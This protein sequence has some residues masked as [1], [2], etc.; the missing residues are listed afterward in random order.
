M[1]IQLA[2]LVLW[3]AINII[4]VCK[5]TAKKLYNDL[6]V[7]QNWF[8]RIAGNLFYLPAWLIIGLYS[9]IIV[10]VFLA[11]AA[12]AWVAEKMQPLVGRVLRGE[13]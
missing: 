11:L 7:E 2:F 1:I 9:A 8:G 5:Y 3:L 10:I 12:L 6:W 4:V 13:L